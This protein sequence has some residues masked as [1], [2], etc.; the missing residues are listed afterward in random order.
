MVRIPLKE[1]IGEYCITVDDGQRIY[2]QIHPLLSAGEPVQL[3]FAGVR[4]VAPPFLNTAIGQLLRDFDIKMLRT[5]L[6]FE[7][8]SDLTKSL[9]ERVIEQAARYFTDPAYRAAVDH[10]MSRYAEGFED[11]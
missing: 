1:Q 6:S 4:I 10:V 11:D 9:L 8:P 3:D 2:E 5:Y 7:N